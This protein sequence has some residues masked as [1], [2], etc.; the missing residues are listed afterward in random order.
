MS[1]MCSAQELSQSEKKRCS[2]WQKIVCRS[3]SSPSR[4]IF[5]V[6]D[7][8]QESGRRPALASWLLLLLDWE[9]SCS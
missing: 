7:L 8:W 9:P 2:H 1:R 3:A 6:D 5:G 4:W